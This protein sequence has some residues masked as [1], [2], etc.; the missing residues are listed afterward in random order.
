MDVAESKAENQQGPTAG[1]ASTADLGRPLG[2]T[3]ATSGATAGASNASGVTAG[4]SSSVSWQENFQPGKTSR[5]TANAPNAPDPTETFVRLLIHHQDDLF[6]YIY[7]LLPH[8]DDAR[9]TLQETCVALFR[10]LDGYDPAKPFLAWAYGFAYLEVLKA[11]HRSS[12]AVRP[13]SDDLVNVL[14]RERQAQDAELHLRLQALESCLEKL[15]PADRDL[16]RERYTKNRPIEELIDQLG[17]SR[18]TLFRNLDRLRRT[19]LDC[20]TRTLAAS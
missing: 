3:S 11:R 1:S 8:Y 13:F 20:I 16:I 17:A 18:R 2:S 9:D 19:L 7:S 5:A 12:R 6:R 10:K 4:L 14:A 15:P